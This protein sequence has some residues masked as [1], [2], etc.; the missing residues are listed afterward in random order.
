MRGE[1]GRQRRIEG[2]SLGC[3]TIV[4][5]LINV[6]VVGPKLRYLDRKAVY[7]VKL[8]NPGDAPAAGVVVSHVVPAGFKF[9]S[10]EVASMTPNPERSPGRWA[11]CP[12]VSR[13]VKC[14]LVASG[15]GDFTHKISATEPRLKAEGTLATRVEGLSALAMEVVDTD[16]PVEVGSETT[17]EI[18][19]ANTGSKDE[20]DVK[21]V[22]VIPPQLKFKSA[23]G[24]GTVAVVGSEVVFEVLKTL[25]A[26]PQVTYKITGSAKEKGD[27]RFKASLTAGGLTEPVIKQESTRVYAD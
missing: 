4:Q 12:R 2:K 3:I 13:R 24:P 1:P 27:A 21:L 18:R 26:R 19:V 11:R 9:A 25:P 17:Y 6:E 16:D 15:T 20:T 14:E 10:A 5:P 23:R 22:C 7:S 8:T